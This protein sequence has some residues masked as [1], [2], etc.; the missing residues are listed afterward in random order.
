MAAFWFLVPRQ[1]IP[2]ALV[3]LREQRWRFFSVSVSRVFCV[4]WCRS[5][6]LRLREATSSRFSRILTKTKDTM[7]STHSLQTK[8]NSI[9]WFSSFSHMFFNEPMVDLEDFFLFLFFDTQIAV[10]KWW[11]PCIG[12]LFTFKN[13]LFGPCREK[14]HRWCNIFSRCYW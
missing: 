10:S 7:Q 13:S 14:K 12:Y 9:H 1:K 8:K 6:I 3:R 5:S 4:W 2:F 11:K